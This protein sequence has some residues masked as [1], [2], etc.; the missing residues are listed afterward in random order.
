MPAS[1]FR[2]A[3]VTRG[4]II[5]AILEA[6]PDLTSQDI[7]ANDDLLHNAAA[8][9][10]GLENDQ[11]AEGHRERLH[12]RRTGAERRAGP[13]DE[14]DTE[15]ET[16]YETAPEEQIQ[17]AQTRQARTAAARFEERHHIPEWLNAFTHAASDLFRGER[18]SEG[19][20]RRA[21]P[22]EQGEL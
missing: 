10:Q 20:A 1:H 14:A 5:A 12:Q 18:G 22:R 19:I 3:G 16:E 9:R 2:K 8:L 13:G 15:M 17:E 11:A 4:E 7:S 6:K 21:T